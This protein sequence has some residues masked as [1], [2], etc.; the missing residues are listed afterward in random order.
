M[1]KYLSL[2]C[3]NAFD[4]LPALGRKVE[5]KKQAPIDTREKLIRDFETKVFYTPEALKFEGT[6]TGRMQSDFKPPFQELPKPPQ[7]RGIL[8]DL[9]AATFERVLDSL[10]GAIAEGGTVAQTALDWMRH[11]KTDADSGV[12]SFLREHPELWEGAL[13]AFGSYASKT[14]RRKANPLPQ[15]AQLAAEKRPLSSYWAVVEKISRLYPAGTFQ[16]EA[17]NTWLESKLHQT[18]MGLDN[19]E[20]RAQFLRAFP[21]L[22]L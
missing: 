22:G 12:T 7:S 20:L 10:S 14:I 9:N 8:S 4:P 19:P 11:L 16:R 17:M 21:Q 6:V 5:P 3:L 1:Q 18:G 15:L 13:F 2:T